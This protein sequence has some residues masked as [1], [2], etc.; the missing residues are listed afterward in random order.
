MMHEASSLSWCFL[1]QRPTELWH[2]NTKYRKDAS[3]GHH[4]INDKSRLIYDLED[5]G[6]TV[7][8]MAFVVGSQITS[9]KPSRVRSK[10]LMVAVKCHPCKQIKFKLCVIS[11]LVITIRRSNVKLIRRLSR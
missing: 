11:M 2:P 1:A 7:S 8:N 5:K 10:S 4:E 3:G 9:Q 6:V